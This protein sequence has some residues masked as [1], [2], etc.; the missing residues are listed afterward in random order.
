MSLFDTDDE[1]AKEAISLFN[2][3]AVIERTGM[4]LDLSPDTV[5]Q[6]HCYGDAKRLLSLIRWDSARY[7]STS[8]VNRLTKLGLEETWARLLVVN[9]TERESAIK[10]MITQLKK[11]DVEEFER[12]VGDV[13]DAVW[14]E[15]TPHIEVTERFGVSMDQ[16]NC[17]M[18]I[19]RWYV[20]DVMVGDAIPATIESAMV[21]GGL[22]ADRAETLLRVMTDRQKDW[23]QIFIFRSTLDNYNTIQEIK[24]QNAIILK[25]LGD[26]QAL[27]KKQKSSRSTQ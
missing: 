17:I 7:D 18:H 14:I 13:M 2:G 15:K 25:A 22:S 10:Y 16:I 11:I 19:A 4:V 3:L 8:I 5:G 1:K 21:E 26:M 9:I 20:N 24:E 27:P 6:T 23:Y 12:T